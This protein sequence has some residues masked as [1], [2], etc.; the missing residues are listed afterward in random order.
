ML[1]SY[2]GSNAVILDSAGNF[3]AGFKLA[4]RCSAT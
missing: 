3:V 1:F 2:A 4:S